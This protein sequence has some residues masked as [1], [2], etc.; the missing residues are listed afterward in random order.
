MVCSICG[1]KSH[2]RTNK[3]FHP[4]GGN[5]ILAG[6]KRKLKGGINFR[7]YTSFTNLTPLDG[8]VDKLYNALYYVKKLG[9]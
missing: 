6:G 8:L 2:I 5:K 4:R 3:R 9:L 1:S 7:K